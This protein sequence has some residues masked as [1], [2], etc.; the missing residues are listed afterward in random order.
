MGLIHLSFLPKTLGFH[1]NVY[2]ILPSERSETTKEF[3]VLYLLHGGAGNAQ[4]WIRYTSIE[5]YAE[6]HGIAVIMPEVGGSS[7]YGDMVHG[8]PY[9]TYL[10]Y[11]LPLVVNCFFPLSKRREER[12]VAGLSMGGY[13]AF[14]WAFDQPEY[15]G[16]AGNFSGISFTEDIFDENRG[17]FAAHA[18]TD[19]RG[20]CNLVWGGYDRMLGTKNDT[21][22]MVTNAT[23][24]K[25]NLPKLY[26]VIGKTDFSYEYAQRYV[27]FLK[28]NDIQIEYH[29]MDGDHEWKVWD[30]AIKEFI[31][32]AIS[33]IKKGL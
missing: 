32:W 28:E 33:T 21:R 31:P 3:P 9:Y 8:Y 6:E 16:A 13:G 19:P 20:I 25:I 11:E 15:F 1:T 29:E 18:K 10:T 7:F 22:Y 23:K 5:R 24:N 30:T 2:A 14:K 26:T 4:D 17:G 27:E 12:F